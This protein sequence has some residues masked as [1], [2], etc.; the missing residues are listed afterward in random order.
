LLKSVT[1]AADIIRPLLSTDTLTLAYTKF[2][3][4]E[5]TDFVSNILRDFVRQIIVSL[6]SH[7]RCGA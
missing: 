1:S 7:S 5:C 6:H 2:V 3:R 4:I